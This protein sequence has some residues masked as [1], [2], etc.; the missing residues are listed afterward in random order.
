MFRLKRVFKNV[1]KDIK[2]VVEDLVLRSY[3]PSVL[4]NNRVIEASRSLPGRHPPFQSGP[5]LSEM[6]WVIYHGI[7]HIL[8]NK[9]GVREPHLLEERVDHVDPLLHNNVDVLATV[10]ENAEFI[11]L[12]RMEPS[13]TPILRRCEAPSDLHDHIHELGGRCN[14][15]RAILNFFPLFAH[16]ICLRLG[17]SG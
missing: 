11:T 4:A 16:L 1:L 6:H 2:G 14:L 7:C 8:G 3:W 5:Y 13:G 12:V 10:I 15:P 9:Q 17:D